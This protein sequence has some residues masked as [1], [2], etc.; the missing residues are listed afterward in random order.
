MILLLA[1]TPRLGELREGPVVQTRIEVG[2]AIVVHVAAPGADGI[3]LVEH[4]ELTVDVLEVS[5]GAWDVT[6]SGPPGSYVI[7]GVRVHLGEEIV[8][9][10]RHFVDLGVD[11]PRSELEPLASLAP[12]VE[13]PLWPWFLGLALTG[14]VTGA[15]I[16]GFLVWK[17]RDTC[18][19]PP[20]P[21]PPDVEALKAWAA[22][23]TRGLDDHALALEL[24]AI[25]RRYLER[26][27]GFPA[28]ALTSPEVLDVCGRVD[29][30]D[31]D[32]AKR[33]LM[34]TDLIKFAREQGS[35]ELFEELGQ[36]LRD[37]V[38]ST[39]PPPEQ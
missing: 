20:P 33:L 30:L 37:I 18:E 5:D 22:A 39:R 17:N 1:C 29:G 11:G 31:R 32:M 38:I 24:S 36:G 34:A 3:E 23:L 2:D 10:P 35:R 25:F 19:P 7:E 12:P 16:T 6:Y 9:G 21:V 14:F 28:T 27:T 4:E 15:G 13:R 26:I 8:E